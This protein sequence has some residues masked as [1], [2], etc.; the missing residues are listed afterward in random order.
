MNVTLIGTIPDIEKIIAASALSTRNKS[1]EML[2]DELSLEKSRKKIGELMSFGH[3]GVSE[4]AFF[5]FAVDGV[6]R[7]LTH[8]LVRHRIAS[9][10]QMSSRHTDLSKMDFVIPPKIEKN[11]E[12]LKILLNSY[13]QSKSDYS[14][15]LVLDI[16]KEDARF[17][18]PDS[19]MTHIV[20][21]MNARS[22]NNF[23]GHRLCNK[24]QW[25]I[26]ELAEKMRSLVLEIVP[27]LFWAA[28]R[29]CVIKG[30]CPE[31]KGCGFENSDEFKIERV[32]YLKGYPNE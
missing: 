18:L 31:K 30:K 25:E 17:I 2:L 8:Q 29:P 4:F 22:L 19:S 26:R 27:S 6:S 12:A 10:L 14:K 7:I 1:A 5:I 23:F 32:R 28:H 20:I 15:L 11:P 24:A 9:Y 3:E 21:G 13:E 16:T